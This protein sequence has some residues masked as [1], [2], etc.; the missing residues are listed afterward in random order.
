MSHNHEAQVHTSPGHY[1]LVAPPLLQ[2]YNLCHESGTHHPSYI[3]RTVYLYKDFPLVP[4]VQTC[5]SGVLYNNKV[6]YEC[7]G[8]HYV[9]LRL[10]ANDICCGGKFYQ[11]LANHQCCKQR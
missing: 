10:N 4:S 9:P 7:C 1:L 5:C 6:G 3:V 2:I 11:P 8:T